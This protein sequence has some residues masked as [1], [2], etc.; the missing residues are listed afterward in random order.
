MK[1]SIAMIVK[2]EEECLGAALESV[3]DADEIV[4]V[5]TGSTDRTME[6]ANKYTSHTY[7]FP[8]VDDFSAA[9]NYANSKCTGD[10]IF[11]LDADHVLVNTIA[12]LRSIC[13]HLDEL[14]ERAGYVRAADS[15]WMA[16]LHKNDPSIKWMGACHEVLSVIPKTKTNLKMK[17]GRSKNHDIDPK[18]NLRILL[19]EYNPKTN[20]RTLRNK[21][22]LG[23]TFYEMGEFQSAVFW[24][25]EYLKSATWLPEKAEAFYV[26]ACCLWQLQKGDEA[27][28]CCMKAIEINA[29]MKKALL[30]MGQM[31][32]PRNAMAWNHYASMAT[33]EDVL[34]T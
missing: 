18:R 23:R 14:G 1:V 27:R 12:E 32:W 9:R 5:D 33:N 4:V 10:W 11:T 29:N 24:M 22:Y 17:I 34:F 2:N 19:N 6:L 20:A 30:L 8:W 25:K 13:A 21:F 26:L 3:K 7:T 28:H 31:S 15:H 16:V